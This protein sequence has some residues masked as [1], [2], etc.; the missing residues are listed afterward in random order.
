MLQK[1]CHTP[2]NQQH[3]PVTGKPVTQTLRRDDASGAQQKKHSQR[4][5][6]QRPEDGAG[7]RAV[8][9]RRRNWHRSAHGF[10]CGSFSLAGGG[11]GTAPVVHGCGFCGGIAATL[12][13][14]GLTW[15]SVEPLRETSRTQPITRNSTGKL[16]SKGTT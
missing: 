8:I 11:G 6:Y 15:P 4:D 10:T 3:W 7:T 14:G 9:W 12:Y 2:D 16:R 5:E 13:H 1:F